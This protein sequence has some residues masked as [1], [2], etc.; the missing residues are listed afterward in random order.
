MS[1]WA[2]GYVS[3][4]NALPLK[5]RREPSEIIDDLIT[6]HGFLR[7]IW[8]LAGRLIKRS[9]PPDAIIQKPRAYDPRIDVLSDHLR[10]DLG[11]PPEGPPK[12]HVDLTAWAHRDLF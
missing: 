8:A 5:N 2:A 1:F 3:V 4:M 9:R 11:L 10:R 7:V 12:A 6:D